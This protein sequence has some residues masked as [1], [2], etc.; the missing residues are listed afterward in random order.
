MKQ[1]FLHL[2]YALLNALGLPGFVRIRGI[3]F[4]ACVAYR[5][6]YLGFMKNSVSCKFLMHYATLK[7]IVGTKFDNNSAGRFDIQTC[8]LHDQIVVNKHIAIGDNSY[9]QLSISLL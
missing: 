7:G 2:V 3:Y 5:N 9:Y 6:N 1:Q 4:N 8:R